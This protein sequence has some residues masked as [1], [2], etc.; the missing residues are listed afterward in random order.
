MEH[1]LRSEGAEHLVDGGTVADIELNQLRAASQCAVQMGSRA[2]AEVIDDQ[3]VGALIHQRVDD[4]R[5][6]EARPPGHHRPRRRVS[7]QR[8]ADPRRG[9]R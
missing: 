2:P 5:T 9:R 7:R 3:H 6:D 1:E 4:V 8:A